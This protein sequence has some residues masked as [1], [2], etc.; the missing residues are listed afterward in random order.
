[1]KA[2]IILLVLLMA[3]AT[4]ARAEERSSSFST[5]PTMKWNTDPAYLDKVLTR[6][7]DAGIKLGKSDFVLGGP[8]VEGLRHRHAEPNR[9]FGQ[10]F[11]GLPVVRWFVPLPMASPPGGGKYFRWG[12]SEKPWASVAAGAAAA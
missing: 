2:R 9:G 10:K 7:S 8:L 12:E 5:S 1:M 6:K 3:G 11:L 4:L